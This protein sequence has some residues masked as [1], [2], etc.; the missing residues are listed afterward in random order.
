MSY[1]KSSIGAKT[2]MAITGVMLILFLV[3]H[4]IGNLLIFAGPDVFNNYAHNLKSMWGGNFVWVARSGLLVVTLV[5]ILSAVRL[6]MLNKNARPQKYQVFKPKRSPFYARVMPMSGLIVLSYIIFHLAHFTVGAVA[7]KDFD[8]KRDGMHNIYAVVIES[9]SHFWVSG[10][11]I[12]S[13]L[14]LCFHLAHGVSSAFQSLGLNHPKYNW[15]FSKAGPVT[16]TLFFVGF[17]S[18]PVATLANII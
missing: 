4:L 15:L 11:Y 5:H 12:F 10:I 9:F 7:V 14:L 18:I 2:V 1:L 3:G 8:A 6:V 13:M 16:G 17:C